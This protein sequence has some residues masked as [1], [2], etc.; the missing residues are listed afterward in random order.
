VEEE[1]VAVLVVVV[2][3][4]VEAVVDELAAAALE[5]DAAAEEEALRLDA[6]DR[7]GTWNEVLETPAGMEAGGGCE[8]TTEGCEVTTEGCEVTGTGWQLRIAG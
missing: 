8:V 7:G 4:V 1:L 5:L 6:E 3:K 2:D